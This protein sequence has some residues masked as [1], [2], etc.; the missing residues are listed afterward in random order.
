MRTIKK[1][2]RMLRPRRKLDPRDIR[3]VFCIRRQ[4]IGPAWHRGY[5]PYS[6]RRPP[7]SRREGEEEHSEE[8]CFRKLQRRTG[9]GSRGVT[10]MKTL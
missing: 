7:L 2:N 1:K 5:C 4:I 3:R 6:S 8:H 9:R 10:L